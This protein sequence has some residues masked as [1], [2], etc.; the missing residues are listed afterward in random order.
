MADN[1]IFRVVKYGKVKYCTRTAISG[2]FA[3]SG[4]GRQGF[5][6]TSVEATNAEATEG[7][8]DVIGE[9]QNKPKPR[10]HYHKAYTGVRKP[11]I[12]SWDMDSVRR[13]F[14]SCH[15]WDIYTEKHPDYQTH[16]PLCSLTYT[17]PAKCS[18]QMLKKILE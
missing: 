15:C 18:C 14:R 8:T 6:I 11:Y 17:D 4:Y 7:W 10:C 13:H 3:S 12:A 1:R 2:M 16:D 5:G 9:F